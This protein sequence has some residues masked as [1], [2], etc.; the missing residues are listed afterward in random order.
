MWAMIWWDCRSFKRLFLAGWSIFDG[1]G[2]YECFTFMSFSHRGFDVGHAHTICRDWYYG[3]STSNH[4]L[5]L[6][7]TGF[8]VGSAPWLVLFGIRSHARVFTSNPWHSLRQ[9]LI[10]N[11]ALHSFLGE[12]LPNRQLIEGTT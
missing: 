5:T 11:L 7:P 1:G 10:F 12:T 3:Q 4:T 6:P 8:F 2:K 9:W